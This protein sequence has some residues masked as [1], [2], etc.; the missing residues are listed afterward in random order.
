MTTA[1]IMAAISEASC[2]SGA[3]YPS[4]LL[5]SK[6]FYVGDGVGGDFFSSTF[7]PTGILRRQWSYAL[8]KITQ[9][10]LCSDLGLCHGHCMAS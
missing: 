7:L 5:I 6:P 10:N 3:L 9:Q 4:S 1:M 8:P 2:I